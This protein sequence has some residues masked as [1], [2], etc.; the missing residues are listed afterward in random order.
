MLCKAKQPKREHDDTARRGDNEVPVRNRHVRHSQKQKRGSRESQPH[1][2]K[3]T[4]AKAGHKNLQSTV[5]YA[6]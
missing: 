3:N 5:R 4:V 6:R 1:E 2:S